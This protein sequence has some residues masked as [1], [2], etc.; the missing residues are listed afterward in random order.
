MKKDFHVFFLFTLFLLLAV[1]AASAGELSLRTSKKGEQYILMP[2]KGTDYLNIDAGTTTFK[3]LPCNNCMHDYV[4][5]S[6]NGTL[7]LTAP[8]GYAIR[9]TS[10][11]FGC[12]IEDGGAH[13]RCDRAIYDGSI[14][15]V[16]DGFGGKIDVQTVGNTMTLNLNSHGVDRIFVYAILTVTILPPKSVTLNQAAGGTAEIYNTVSH[17]GENVRV[18]AFPGMNHLLRGLEI[19]DG[20]NVLDDIL[21]NVDWYSERNSA[22]FAMP[23]ANV[24]VTPVFTSDLTAEGGLYLNMPNNSSVLN[25]AIPGSVESFKL[26]D[27]GGKDGNYGEKRDEYLKLTAPKGYLIQVTGNVQAGT[28][29]NSCTKSVLN[30]DNESIN[31]YCSYM[32]VYDGI[33][34]FAG[35]QNVSLYNSIGT[36]TSHRVDFGPVRST[37]N[38]A[39]V[40]FH[41]SA[42]GGRGLD[43][44]VE[45]IRLSTVSLGENE[46]LDYKE[47]SRT[48]PL[49]LYANM[50]SE[51]K[52][53]YSLEYRHA[54][55]GVWSDWD[56]MTHVVDYALE[57]LDEHSV[58]EIPENGVFTHSFT[59]PSSVLK[60]PYEYMEFRY[61]MTPINENNQLVTSKTSYTSSVKVRLM[62]KVKVQTNIG[63]LNGG[64]Y[65]VTMDNGKITLDTNNL[66]PY[67]TEI[68]VLANVPVGYE[69]KCW[70]PANDNFCN[71][72]TENPVTF[73]VVS[74]TTLKAGYE[75][76]S[77]DITLVT[78]ISANGTDNTYTEEDSPM[79]V[80]VKNVSKFAVKSRIAASAE[81][82]G[83]EC[84]AYTVIR[85]VGTNV[86]DTVG[87]VL[88]VNSNTNFVGVSGRHNM[89]N[90]YLTGDNKMDG[91]ARFEIKTVVTDKNGK[92]TESKSV[93]AN[94]FRTLQFDRCA[95]QFASSGSIEGCK[96]IVEDELGNELGDLTSKNIIV[97]H[98]AKV[99]LH[100]VYPYNFVFHS[101]KDAQYG[102]LNDE[103]TYLSKDTVYELT[104]EPTTS[105]MNIALGVKRRATVTVNSVYPENNVMP[106]AGMT[107]FNLVLNREG[108]DPVK[109]DFANDTA[110]FIKKNN[111][112]FAVN[113]LDSMFTPGTYTLTAKV[114]YGAHY[115]SERDSTWACDA[116]PGLKWGNETMNFIADRDR[117]KC[118]ETSP[119]VFY[120]HYTFTVRD[121]S[122]NVTF[123]TWDEQQKEYVAVAAAQKVSFGQVPTTPD[124]E[125]PESNTEWNFSCNW[126]AA[127]APAVK[128]TVYTYQVVRS[129]SAVSVATVD[130]KKTATI[131]GS[132]DGDESFKI[133]EAVEVESVDFQRTFNRSGSGFSTIVL[134][135]DVN[136]DNLTGVESVIEFTGMRS[137]GSVGMSYVWCSEDVEDALKEEASKTS[138]PE[139]YEH[140]NSVKEKF[141]GEMKAYVPYM[142]QMADAKLGF[143]Y[144]ASV[145]LEPT[146]ANAEARVG[147]WVFRGTTAKKVFDA[148]ETKDGNVW[149]FAAEERDGARIGEFV[150]LGVGASA[151]PLRAYMVFAPEDSDP[152]AQLVKASKNATFAA[153]PAKANSIAGA[154]TAAL[155]DKIDVVIVSR[156]DNNGE[157]RTVI[158]TL[159]TR[160]GEFKMLRDYDLKG[161]KVNGV[162]RARGAYYGKKV[163]KK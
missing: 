26:Y 85:K 29:Y 82:C 9:A 66:I 79:E 118:T 35:N 78:F 4:K 40:F 27:D 105:T 121:T 23:D 126:I 46:A 22:Q 89:M 69:F 127:F 2:K 48:D 94:L 12:H 131:E 115:Q 93:F 68:Q 136:A 100:P 149:G 154:E 21:V 129:N 13:T 117:I 153:K 84:A 123:N 18:D 103:S 45:L 47:V 37:G 135:F 99:K 60:A 80:N 70:N 156:D 10:D 130:G 139:V 92:V 128:D 141:T 5:S 90:H 160:T 7:V 125:C 38:T 133:T 83:E 152:P 146:P 36:G 15:L 107:E 19:K 81:L 75:S 3:I 76:T 106:Y 58:R 150:R 28:E 96:V 43:L 30:N 140:C 119:A 39:T 143:D 17:F 44:T 122:F 20:N 157:H 95:I 159:Y 77:K 87:K 120:Y 148:E 145:T 102:G 25:V 163:L 64:K 1:N 73:T 162:N 155:S 61:S 147:D 142:V 113:G 65:S 144:V 42:W 52:F 108:D 116:I 50:K 111:E 137:D 114:A 33:Y 56:V 31:K 151:Q 72:H 8:E 132:Y 59:F 62:N 161:R 110:F 54:E 55:G 91:A 11:N 109:L 74:D 98:G 24:S 67:G 112:M 88:Y 71:T 124:V 34:D 138:T 6:V 158:G 51:E 32:V 86:W 97:Q 134:P 16:A 41:A 104:V 101:W 49:T 63:D 14:A 57:R 53:Q